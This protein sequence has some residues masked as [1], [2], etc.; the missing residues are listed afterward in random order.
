MA[1]QRPSPKKHLPKI[2]PA[3]EPGKW[4]LADV[5][6]VQ[7]LEHGRATPE[8]QR[9]ALNWILYQACKLGD[10]HFRPGGDDGRRETDFAL[11]RVFPAQQIVKLMRLNLA[12][13][14]RREPSADPHEDQ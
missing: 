7:A 4:E 13:L 5:A 9:R 10:F 2:P 3:F 11:G 6:A 14:P 1:E 8:Q 12:A